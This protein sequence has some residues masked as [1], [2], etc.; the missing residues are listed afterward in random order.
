[1]TN[2]VVS[3]KQARN[4]FADLLGQVK[5]GQKVVTIQKQGK[6]FGVLISPEQ[7]EAYQKATKDNLFALIDKIQ[8]RNGQSNEAE[9]TKDIAEAVKEARSESYEQAK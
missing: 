1:M 4:N 3:S 9:V 6:A 5:F 2:L 7:Y 8:S